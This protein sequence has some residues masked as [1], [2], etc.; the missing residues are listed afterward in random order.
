[1][2]SG[3][4][5]SQ[6][7]L[8]AFKELV[9]NPSQRGLLVTISSERLV[10]QQVLPANGSFESDLL[11]LE[12]LLTTTAA[13]YI[14]LRRYEGSIKPPFVAVTYVPDTANV[15]QKMLFASTRNT[16]LRELGKDRFDE[17]IF[18]TL[19]SELTAEGFERHDAHGAKPSPLTEE[20]RHLKDV[21]DLE[22]ENSRGT[23]S[24][25]SHVSSGIAFPLS[26]E[27][28]FMLKSLHTATTHNLVQLAIDTTKETIE[29]EGCEAIEAQNLQRAISNSAP[30]FS[31]F[32]FHHTY[33]G[34]STSP[35]VFIYTCPSTS[36]IKERM[37]Y[38]S[39]RSSII[40]IA[41]QAGLQISK[42][43][44]AAS[45]SELS[46]ELLMEEF[47]PKKEEKAS[48]AR[49]KRPGRR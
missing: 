23:S 38:A 25:K 15:R 36:K 49:P 16:L 45:P 39:S 32:V 2:Q 9:S 41:E 14:I 1:M 33:D 31:F 43:L 7:L 19:K 35:V 26:P 22:A 11:Q 29:L 3:I 17:D 30:R 46:L 42:R 8:D 13:A 4:S 5:A 10:P 37:V 12:D 27:A 44:E 48:F 21:R 28:Q 47:H 6:E 24:R 20:E 34:E 40:S 18:A